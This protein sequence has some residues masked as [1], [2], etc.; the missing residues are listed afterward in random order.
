MSAMNWQITGNELANQQAH[1]TMTD[2][3]GP[4]KIIK[5]TLWSQNMWIIHRHASLVQY[6]YFICNETTEWIQARHTQALCILPRHFVNCLVEAQ[7]FCKMP[8]VYKLPRRF[9]KWRII[10]TACNIHII[11]CVSA[12]QRQWSCFEPWILIQFNVIAHATPP[13]C[14]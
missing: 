10:Q 9:A 6:A 1:H 3:V 2:Q 5:R 13:V 12:R 8:A 14:T 7:A 4:D 11:W